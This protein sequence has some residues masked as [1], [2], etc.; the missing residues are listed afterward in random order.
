[1]DLPSRRSLFHTHLSEHFPKV[2]NYLRRL[3][4]QPEIAEDLTQ[5]S[6]LKAWQA[7]ARFAPPQPF[8]PWILQI[9]RRTAWDYFRKHREQAGP[10]I[11]ELQTDKRPSPE[12]N[13]LDQENTR[14]LEAALQQLPEAQRTAVFL[15]YKEE[16]D[17][18]GLAVVLKSTKSGVVS[19]LHR[20]RQRLKKALAPGA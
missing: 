2:Y 16:L 10:G 14:R 20:A 9:A 11:L 8:L 17:V 19:L 7:F 18:A 1:M 6:F 5:E 4:R 12:Q 3:V 15:Y 13:A